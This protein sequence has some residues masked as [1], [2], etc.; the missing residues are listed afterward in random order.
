[1]PRNYHG[2][3]NP[4]IMQDGGDFSFFP[5]DLSHPPLNSQ[6]LFKLFIKLFRPSKRLV[7]FDPQIEE[8]SRDMQHKAIKSCGANDKQAWVLSAG[9][10]PSQWRWQYDQRSQPP[11]INTL[12]LREDH[13]GQEQLPRPHFL[14]PTTASHLTS[15][16]NLQPLDQL[17]NTPSHECANGSDHPATSLDI[18]RQNTEG[19]AHHNYNPVQAAPSTEIPRR[20]VPRRALLQLA[21]VGESS[22]GQPSALFKV[23]E[24]MIQRCGAK[25]ITKMKREIRATISLLLKQLQCEGYAELVRQELFHEFTAQDNSP[26][27]SWDESQLAPRLHLAS[28][29]FRIRQ[30]LERLSVE[31]NFVNSRGYLDRLQAFAGSVPSLQIFVPQKLN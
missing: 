25:E 24:P 28:S 16:T 21:N 18:C 17:R 23:D 14:R 2:H 11:V 13:Q 9:W 4:Y 10:E 31:I 15:L 22:S 1:M 30:R 29:L 3:G 20:K 12:P 8:A 6:M 26:Q 19:F 27:V 5:I 7:H